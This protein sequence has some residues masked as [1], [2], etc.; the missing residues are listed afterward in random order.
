MQMST[1]RFEKG[2]G[3]KC[4]RPLAYTLLENFSLI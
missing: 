4:Q 1:A 2:I 3:V